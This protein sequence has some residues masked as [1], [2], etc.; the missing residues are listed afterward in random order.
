[1][2][3]HPE[4]IVH[5]DKLYRNMIHLAR[6]Q[7]DLELEHLLRE[8][9]R[10]SVPRRCATADGCEI[11]ELA[12]AEGSA[13]APTEALPYW[14]DQTFW[15]DLLQFLAFFSAS[16]AGFLHVLHLITLRFPI[17]SG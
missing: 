12:T 11:I 8:R 2:R 3:H 10:N 1:M 14:K 4:R 9:L 5:S 6:R 13:S 15:T 7:D 16:L 17:H